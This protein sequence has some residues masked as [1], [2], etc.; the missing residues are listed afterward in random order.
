MVLWTR[1]QIWL[2]TGDGPRRNGQGEFNQADCITRSIGMIAD[3][4]Q[5]MV[6][7]DEGVWFQGS[8][9]EIYRIGNGGQIE[10]LGKPV[11]EYLQ[12]YPKVVAAVYRQGK[13]EVAFAITNSLGTLGGILRRNALVPDSPAWFFDDVGAVSSL[14]EYQGRLAYVQSGIVYL[15]DASPGSGAFPTVQLDSGLFQG[16]QALG[17]G[18]LQELGVLATFRGRCTI[19]LKIGTDGITFPDTIAAW[20]LSA[21]EYSVGQR[22]Q[23]LIDAPK[24]EFDSFAIRAEVSDV[25]GTTEG[26]WLHAFAVKTESKPDFVRLAPSRRL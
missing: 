23:L 3:G 8:D 25:T 22:V 10:W 15:Q 12:T 21:T 1:K 20:A 19:T 9:A 18:A 14:A 24:Q 4:W 7:D 13:R 5:S 6:Q 26:A 11:R 17:Y 16:F 2:V